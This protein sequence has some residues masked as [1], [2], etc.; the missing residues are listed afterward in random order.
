MRSLLHRFDRFVT[1]YIQAWPKGL[2]PLMEGAT[3]LGHPIVVLAI[4]MVLLYPEWQLPGRAAAIAGMTIV[5]TIVVSSVLKLFLRRK[6]PVTY[7]MKKWFSTFSFPSG[8]TSGTT[9][10]YGVL[11]VLGVFFA[12]TWLAVAVAVAAV[13]LIVLVGLS[14]VYLGAHYPSDVV[15]GWILGIAG[16]GCFILGV[17]LS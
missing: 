11:A 7:V 8:H 15:A 5:G 12:S 6:R 1:A 9:A 17:T 3:T 16:V 2:R 13:A 4:A 10:A 14:R